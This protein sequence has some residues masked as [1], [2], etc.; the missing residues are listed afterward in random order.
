MADA[1]PRSWPKT[2]DSVAALDFVKICP[3]HCPVLGRQRMTD[4]RNY[5]EELTEKVEAGKKAGKSIADLQ[6]TIT[7]ASLRSMQSNAYG[8]YVSDNEYKYFPSFGPATPLQDGVNTNIAE[9]YNTL[10]K[11]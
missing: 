11:T 9:V 10:E 8:K 3:G 4:M 6:K 5:I 2:M 1:F 7:L